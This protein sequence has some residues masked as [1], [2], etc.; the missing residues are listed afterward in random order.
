[1]PHIASL[2]LGS[3]LTSPF[4][5]CQAAIRSLKANP[6]IQVMAT[7][8]FYRTAPVGAAAQ[9]DFV[10]TAVALSTDCD[11]RT[12]FQI[13]SDIERSQGRLRRN[14]NEARVIDID[15]ILFDDLVLQA[16]DLIIP[17]P[18][19]RERRFVLVPLAEIAPDTKDPITGLTIR[20]LL[21]RTDDRSE[22]S[23][24]IDT[25]S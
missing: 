3:N 1:M 16:E 21:Q 18:R 11:A 17:H 25:A 23:L 19:F 12:L 14:R 22:V 5:Q 13:I 24:I 8:S 7:A 4:N 6:A 2:S 15:L 10:N 9:P 20:E